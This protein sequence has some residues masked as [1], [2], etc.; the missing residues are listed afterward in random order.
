VRGKAGQALEASLWRDGRQLFRC[1]SVIEA[2]E[3]GGF[4]IRCSVRNESVRDATFEWGPY[5]ETVKPG[6]EREYTVKSAV[7][8]QEA[9]RGCTVSFAEDLT[10]TFKASAWIKP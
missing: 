2:G 5:K 3:S 7:T 10:Y 9:D 6:Q 4:V 8:P 1:R